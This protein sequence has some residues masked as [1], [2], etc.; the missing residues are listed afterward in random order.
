MATAYNL[1]IREAGRRMP[2]EGHWATVRQSFQ[3]VKDLANK[4]EK[5]KLILD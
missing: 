3:K 2:Q 4:T 1:S 5:V